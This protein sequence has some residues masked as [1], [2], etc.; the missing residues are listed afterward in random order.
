MRS[1]GPGLLLF[2]TFATVIGSRGFSLA[3]S[4]RSRSW[5]CF[6]SRPVWQI[7]LL[8]ISLAIFGGLSF[9][10]PASAG[11]GGYRVERL[12]VWSYEHRV[13]MRVSLYIQA[14]RGPFPLAIISHGTSS[15][16][17]ER[18]AQDLS[19]YAGVAEWFVS[20]GYIVAVPQR[21]GHGATGGEWVEGY[22]DCSDPRYFEAGIAAAHEIAAVR[23]ALAMRPDVSRRGVLLV[24]HSA[25]A[26][27]S[28]A[29]ASEA[30]KG[31]SAVINF[32]G[33]LGGRSYDIAHRICAPERLI[34]AAARYGASTRVPTLWI[35]GNNDTYF[36]PMISKAMADAFV[37]AGGRASY[38][39]LLQGNGEGHFILLDPASTSKWSPVVT[40]FLRHVH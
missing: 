34:E 10:R 23:A 15:N 7:S 18:A 21:P 26:W 31:I 11:I 27:A 14:G 8:C 36:D 2:A 30:G 20:R 40:E 38:R 3:C 35:Y 22:G 9:S 24:G 25:G 19:P 17:Q 4:R 5:P 12:Q 16:A 1:N 6:A 33:G 13:R 32:A 37:R 39:L 29:L 28:L